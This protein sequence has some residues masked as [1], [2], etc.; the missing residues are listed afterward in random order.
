MHR[1]FAVN[2]DLF[3]VTLPDVNRAGLFSFDRACALEHAMPGREGQKTKSHQQLQVTK[4]NLCS[5]GTLSFPL[6]S[7]YCFL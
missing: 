4:A 2:V 3:S 1:Y 6:S 5:A 7:P